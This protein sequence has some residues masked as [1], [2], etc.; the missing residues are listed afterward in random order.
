[1][2][3]IYSIVKTALESAGYVVLVTH[4]KDAAYVLDPDAETDFRIK[5]EKYS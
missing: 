2:D 4:D 3:D 5:V 1:M